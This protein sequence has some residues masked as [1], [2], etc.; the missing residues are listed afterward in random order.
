MPE[1]NFE[2]KIKEIITNKPFDRCTGCIQEAIEKIERAAEEEIENRLGR[3]GVGI[4]KCKK[5]GKEII[6]IRTRGGNLMPTNLDLIS[7]F[8]T[9][10]FA[11]EFRKNQPKEL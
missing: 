4:T 6:F 8:A 10:K 7:H 3:I 5:C 1:D 11:N 9:C 2:E